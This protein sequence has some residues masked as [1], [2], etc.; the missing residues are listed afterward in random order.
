VSQWIVDASLTLG[1]YLGTRPVEPT[2]L[3]SSPGLNVA[4]DG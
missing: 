2:T 4:D 3:T 1:W